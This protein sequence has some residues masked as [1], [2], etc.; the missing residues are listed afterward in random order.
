VPLIVRETWRAA[1]RELLAV[2][3]LADS[4]KVAV[5]DKTRRASA[6]TIGLDGGE[7]YPRVP[8]RDK[9]YAQLSGTRLQLTR[10][11]RKALSQ[12]AAETI[13]VLW[14][15]W[16]DTA[17]FDE[18][19]RIEC[20]KGQNERQARAHR[21]VFAAGGDSRGA[22]RMPGRQMDRNR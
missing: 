20:V 10:M 17:M 13:R 11:G 19:A 12:P 15:K 3:R 16:L 2:L 1:Q 4:G 7:Y 8:P 21:R 5:I 22:R 6:S 9:W 18:L 14:E